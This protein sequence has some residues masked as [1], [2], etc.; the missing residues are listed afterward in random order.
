MKKSP[1]KPSPPRGEGGTAAFAVTNEGQKP[2][3][4]ANG[5]LPHLY[6]EAVIPNR[7]ALKYHCKYFCSGD[8]DRSWNTAVLGS[9]PIVDRR[10]VLYHIPAPR[11]HNVGIRRVRLQDSLLRYRNLQYMGR[12]IFAYKPS[13]VSFL[14]NHTIG[15]ALPSSCSCEVPAHALY[16]LHCEADLPCLCIIAYP[17]LQCKP[18]T[19]VIKPNPHQS[20]SGQLPPLYGGSLPC[21]Y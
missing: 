1:R 6:G 8:E 16:A 3:Q 20:A 11:P 10:P 18:S 13:S 14:E 5:Q 21:H 2:H 19:K 7:D 9:R 15:G 17:F 12:A 4:S